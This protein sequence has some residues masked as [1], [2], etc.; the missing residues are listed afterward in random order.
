MI[1]IDFAVYN[2][3]IAAIAVSIRLSYIWRARIAAV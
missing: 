1:Y 2:S 3:V